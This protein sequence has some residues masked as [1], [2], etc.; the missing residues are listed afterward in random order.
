MKYNPEIHHRRSIRL[1]GYDYSRAGAYFATVCTQNRE[2]RLGNIVD[3][4]MTV[5]DAGRIACEAW[6]WLA[7]QYNHVELDQ[8]AIMPNHIHGIIVVVDGDNVRGIDNVGD[9]GSG[10]QWLI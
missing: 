4:K 6:E 9:V 8:C 1:Q 3:G 5:N 7:T 10:G 2:C